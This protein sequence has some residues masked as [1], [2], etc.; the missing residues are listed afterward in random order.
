M[1]DQDCHSV[2]HAQLACV[3]YLT[4]ITINGQHSA[5]G[6]RFEYKSSKDVNTTF[7]PE[8][9]QHLFLSEQ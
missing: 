3:M 1:C 2:P 9:I 6:D 7:D 8:K 5:A 4:N